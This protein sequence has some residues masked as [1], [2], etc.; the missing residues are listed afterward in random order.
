[1]GRGYR[2]CVIFI[3]QRDD[4]DVL[5]PN[6]ELDPRFGEAIRKAVKN[7]VEVYAYSSE[8]IG[9]NILLRRKIDVDL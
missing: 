9:N 2:A 8:F 7:G 4:A 6:D 1:M 5:S 3:V